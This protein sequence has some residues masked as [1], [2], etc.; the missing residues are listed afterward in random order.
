MFLHTSAEANRLF[1]EISAILKVQNYFLNFYEANRIPSIMQPII[2][3][4]GPGL[5][6]HIGLITALTKNLKLNV[7][8]LEPYEL[9][10][11]RH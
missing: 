1:S 2:N 3:G 10:L 6:G 8:P 4:I 11:S 7:C 9:I 5:A